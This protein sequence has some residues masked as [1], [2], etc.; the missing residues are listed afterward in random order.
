MILEH[1]ST[2]A[3]D[4]LPLE[5]VCAARERGEADLGGGGHAE[6]GERHGGGL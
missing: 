1:L 4:E 6:L 5:L 3:L 2:A